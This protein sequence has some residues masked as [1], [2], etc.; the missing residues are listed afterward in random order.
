MPRDTNIWT[1][2]NSKI[3]TPVHKYLYTRTQI[4][5]HLVFVL[6][7]SDYANIKTT[8]AQKVGQPVAEKTLLGWTVMSP[9]KEVGPILLT[10]STTIDYEQLCELDVL[11]LQDSNENDQKTVYEEFEKQLSSRDQAGW[12]ET[13][14]TWKG[15]HP[16]LPTNENSSKR[17]LEQLLKKLER[18]GQ[19][20]KYN[21]IIQQQLN[22]GVIELAPATKTAKEFYILGHKG[23]ERKQA[24]TTK[25]RVVYDASA[26]ESG[27][28]PSLNDCLHPGPP[29]QNLL[30]DV[31]V[32][33][34]FHPILLTGD[35]K[36]AFLQIRI[37][38]EDRDSLRFHWKETG[39]DAIQIYRFTRALFGLTCCPFLFGGVLLNT[40]WVLGKIAIPR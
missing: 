14:L 37:K 38:A 15:N 8:T 24:E 36:Q 3:L 30:W 6:G 28:R 9:G 18:S 40:I 33:S 31:L 25:L 35:L 7:D 10:Q 39:N 11:G 23:I 34:R 29:L 13:S 17:R 16:P 32:R 21:D 22:Q 1:V 2:Q 20:S 5:I 4:P 26:K 12:Y 27:S 19:Y